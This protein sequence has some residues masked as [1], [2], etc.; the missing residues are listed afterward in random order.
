[1]KFTHGAEFRYIHKGVEYLL[2]ASFHP[3]QQNTFTGKLTREMLDFVLEKA[4]R[5]AHAIE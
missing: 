1:V 4:G 2:I 3:S 5:F